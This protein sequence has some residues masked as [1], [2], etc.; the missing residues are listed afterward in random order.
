M[1]RISDRIVFRADQ[2]ISGGIRVKC[3]L[4]GSDVGGEELVKEVKLGLVL[5]SC[6]SEHAGQNGERF[7]AGIGTGTERYFA[8]K[9]GPPQSAFRMIV[10]GW[11]AR[12][13]EEGE[14]F[15]GV[16]LGIQETVA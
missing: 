14:E 13:G 11:H 2:A 10:S 5:A 6:R 15:L 8:C 4:G 1:A 9:H 3:G 7:G 12:A 16:S